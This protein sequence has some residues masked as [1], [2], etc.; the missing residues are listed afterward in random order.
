MSN[1]ELLTIFAAVLVIVL[2]FVVILALLYYL[3][4]A[5]GL[6]KIAKNRGYKN[7]WMAFVPIASSYLIGGIADHINSCS[8]KQSS[9]RIWML[10][11]SIFSVVSS[12]FVSV[13]AFQYMEEII[14]LA[15]YGNEPAI[16]DIYGRMMAVSGISSIV[17]IAC[18]V[19]SYIVLYKIYR[20]YSQ[21]ATVFLVLSILAPNLFGIQLSPFFLFALRNKPSA[22]I[23]YQQWIKQQPYG[24]PGQPQQPPQQPFM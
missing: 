15:Y 14:Q 12:V 11:A 19:I 9:W 8:G 22:S 7:A 4:E 2:V 21:N 10:I 5:I 17:S 24:Y 3:F 23:A 13:F 16:W 6:Y 18:M 20:D 1:A